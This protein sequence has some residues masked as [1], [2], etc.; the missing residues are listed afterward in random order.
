VGDGGQC[1]S[2]A[3][4]RDVRPFSASTAG[5]ALE[6]SGFREAAMAPADVA[7]TPQHARPGTRA[8]HVW[9]DNLKVVLVVAVI[10]GHATLAWTGGVGNWVV[11][12]TPV[13]EP[14]LTVLL[15]VTLVGALFAMPLFFLLAGTFTPRS[16]ARKSTR[17]GQ[18]LRPRRPGGQA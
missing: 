12:E 5:A 15:L 13:R 2:A 16:P 3:R 4:G 14:L 8:R 18:G 6:I 17:V 11:Y 7:A 10:V 1:I 9:A